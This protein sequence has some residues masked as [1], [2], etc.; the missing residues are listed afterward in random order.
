MVN[1]SDG[2]IVVGWKW[3]FKHKHDANGN[4]LWD[5]ARPDAQW[6]IDYNEVFA[7][8]AKYN[9]ICTVLVIANDLDPEIHQMDITTMVLNGDL[10]E[11]IYMQQ[12]DGF[13]DKDHLKWFAGCKKACMDWSKQHDAGTKQSRILQ[14][15][16]ICPKWCWALHLLQTCWGKFCNC[17]C[18]RRWFGDSFKWHR[19]ALEKKKLS[20]RLTSRIKAKFTIA[21]AC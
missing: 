10:E 6:S 1:L 4:I 14:K 11:E 8:V 9:S 19:A 21:L 15:P 18:I 2:K 12:P 17:H 13:V 5:K 16:W 3:V 20:E 7:P